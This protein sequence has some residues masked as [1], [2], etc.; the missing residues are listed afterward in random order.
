MHAFKK[1]G[2]VEGVADWRGGGLE[3]GGVRGGGGDR[4]DSHAIDNLSR[5][6]LNNMNTLTQKLLIFIL[7]TKEQPYVCFC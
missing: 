6:N 4:S 1:G 7:S 5:R 2:K 3:R